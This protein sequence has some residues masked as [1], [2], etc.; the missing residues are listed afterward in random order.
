M[1]RSFRSDG[2]LEAHDS[3]HGILCG[4]VVH[5]LAPDAQLLFANWEAESPD[6]FLDAVR[7]AREQGRKSITCSIIMPSW[8]DGEG[9]GPVHHELKRILGGNRPDDILCF[10]SAGNTATR[11]WTGTYRKAGSGYHEWTMGISANPLTPWGLERVSVELCWAERADFEVVVEDAIT[12]QTVAASSVS[13]G[14]RHAVQA[15]FDPEKSRTYCVRVRQVRGVAC[16]FQCVALGG[17]LDYSTT[18]G[19]VCF[20]GD[21]AE[22]IAVG[23]VD[24]DGRR[25]SYSS[26]GFAAPRL[27]PDLMATVP[28]TSLWRDKPFSGTSAASPQA[29]ALAALW[30]SRHPNW[31]ALKIREVMCN[32]ARDIGIPGPDNE[33]G[34]GLIQLPSE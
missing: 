1:T 12:G 2:N 33:T 14:D 4:E 24:A 3:Q 29:A 22:V 6:S 31:S 13:D 25:M 7:W 32:T 28:F 34:Y 10:A 16:A 9:G 23:A 27:K 30:R 5:A 26:C 21:G 17:N 8:G 15:R 20:P 11:T 19:S 18:C